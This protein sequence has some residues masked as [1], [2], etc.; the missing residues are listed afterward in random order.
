MPIAGAS[1]C[2]IA[3]LIAIAM[4]AAASK[5]T[6][7]ALEQ[8]RQAMREAESSLSPDRAAGG[9]PS[10]GSVDTA[11]AEAERQAYLS[12]IELRDV[13]V[14]RS[15][16]DEP[17][18]FGEVKNTGDRTLSKVTIVVYCLG[19]DGRPVYEKTFSPVLVT[20]SP[21]NDAE[22]LKPN[23]AEKFGYSLEDAPSDWSGRVTAKVTNVAFA[24]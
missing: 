6:H 15:V 14:G 24:D 5:V 12:N 16:L 23:Y 20:D 10:S 18:V 2:G 22:P 9:S 13:R 1:I 19:G 4:T 11:T 3:I 7:D 21:F 17:G 8:T